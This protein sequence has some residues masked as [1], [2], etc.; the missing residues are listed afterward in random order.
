METTDLKKKR[1]GGNQLRTN[2]Q[3]EFRK[4]DFKC[5]QEPQIVIVIRKWV[6]CEMIRNNQSEKAILNT[7]LK[8]RESQS[9]AVDVE[10]W[11]VWN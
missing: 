5:K 11:R 10:T 1:Q 8:Y 6:I 7:T 9:S 2:Q 4:C 3:E